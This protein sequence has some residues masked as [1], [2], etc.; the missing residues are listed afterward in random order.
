MTFRRWLAALLVA[1]APLPAAAQDD[2]PATQEAFANMMIRELQKQ[3]PEGEFVPAADDPLAITASGFNGWEDATINFHRPYYFC[4]E[5]AE[6]DCAVMR[7]EFLTNISTPPPSFTEADLRVIVRHEEY[8]AYV[9]DSLPADQ[10]IAARPVGGELVAMLALDSP[11]SIAV[12]TADDLADFGLD[13]EAA[14]VLA[15]ANTRAI[16]PPL[17]TGDDLEGLMVFTDMEYLSSMA[18]PPADW[19]EVARKVGPDL[20]IAPIDDYFVVVGR[21]PDA[22]LPGLREVVADNCRASAR[23]LSPEVLRFRNGQWVIAR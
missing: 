1:L 15:Q 2:T 17:P 23:C 18:Y 9:S 20:F 11:T 19:A 12:A 22:E 8:L 4:L 3:F 14:W 10:R 7:A 13:A 21:V 6:A 5:N 16:L